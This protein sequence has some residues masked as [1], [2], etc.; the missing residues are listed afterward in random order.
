MKGKPEASCFKLVDT[1]INVGQEGQL[2]H[3]TQCAL[4]NSTNLKVR[5]GKIWSNRKIEADKIL[6][7][8]ECEFV[9]L[10]D[11][12]HISDSHYEESLM[13]ESRNASVDLEIWRQETREDDERRFSLLGKN[14]KDMEVLEVGIGNAGFLKL[15]KQVGLVADGIEPAHQFEAIFILEGLTVYKYIDQIKKVYDL[16]LSFHVIEHVKNPYKFIEELLKVTK[17][18]GEIYIETPNSNDALLKLYDSDSFQNYTYWDN[19]LGLFSHKSLTYLLNKFQGITFDFLPCQR[20]GI[21]N[22]LHW[23]SMKLPG[24]H[25]KWGFLDSK[26]LNLEYSRLLNLSKFND[27]LLVRIKKE[28]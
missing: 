26:E 6:E 3:S 21:A 24:G 19:H 10:N 1:S 15:L 5:K 18:G 8:Q 28:A 20:Y 13:L 9:F 12:T 11:S 7:C 2:T 22:H 14:V 25:W 4:C 23:L 27:T 17:I 16:V